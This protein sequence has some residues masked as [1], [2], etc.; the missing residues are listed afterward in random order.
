MNTPEKNPPADEKHYH[1]SKN[2]DKFRA[3]FDAVMGGGE[4]YEQRQWK[5]EK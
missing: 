5:G 1:G 2:R 4:S 3:R